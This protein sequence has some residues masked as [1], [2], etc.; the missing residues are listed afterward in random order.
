MI[1][2]HPAVPL[3][4]H[5]PDIPEAFDRIIRKALEK[6]PAMRWKSAAAMAAAIQPFIGT[7]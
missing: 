6:H 2:E 5:R 7:S 4:A 1:L 3:R